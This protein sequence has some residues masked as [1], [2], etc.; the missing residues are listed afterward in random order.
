MPL[1]QLYR[2][3]DLLVRHRDKIEA[4]LFG[5]IQDLFGLPVTVTLYDLTNTYF[6]GNPKAAL[7]RSKEKRSDCGLVTPALVLGRQRVCAPLE[8]V[9]RQ[10]GRK[11]DNGGHAPRPDRVKGGAGYHGRG[12]PPRRPTS[13]GSKSKSIA[14]SWSAAT[15]VAV[16]TRTRPS[17][18]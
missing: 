12:D 6:E 17:I 16:S 1:M 14:T 5:R 10:R 7:G 15:A 2:T 3:S 13:P 11:H 4:A 18:R 8:D 9:R